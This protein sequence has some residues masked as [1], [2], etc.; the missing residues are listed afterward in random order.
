MLVLRD[1]QL[2]SLPDLLMR[3]AARI[4]TFVVGVCGDR[5]YVLHTDTQAH[6]CNPSVHHHFTIT[7]SA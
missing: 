2:T 4:G 6:A 5:L 3:V 7:I 1:V